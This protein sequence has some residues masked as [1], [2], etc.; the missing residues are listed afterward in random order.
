MNVVDCHE[1]RAEYQPQIITN[2]KNDSVIEPM[3]KDKDRISF[4]ESDFV[5]V[6]LSVS[7]FGDEKINDG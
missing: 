7:G 4:Q 2:G 3:F 6:K 5:R 1:S